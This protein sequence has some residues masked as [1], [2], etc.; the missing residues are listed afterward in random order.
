MTGRG[1]QVTIAAT[2]TVA[3]VGL[4][5]G[6]RGTGREVRSMASTAPP[7][8]ARVVA[9]SYADL[10]KAP[11]GVNAA[12]SGEWFP[13]LRAATAP[14]LDAP[15][16]QTDE[17][18][19][20]AV[21]ARAERRAFDGAPPTIPHRV[22]QLGVP[23]CLACHDAGL[24]VATKVAP[25]MSHEP[26]ASCLQ[27]HV[28][29]ADPRAAVAAAGGTPAAPASDFVGRRADYRGERAWTGAPPQL[30]HS[31]QM[32]ERC[33]SCH[34]PLGALGV[35][36]THPWRQSC[37]QCHAPSATFE[38]RAPVALPASAGGAPGGAR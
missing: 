34:G 8:A 5:S 11:R 23:A 26:M 3:A 24:V 9:P 14:K 22:D 33:D 2:L 20:R 1:L 32:R 21:A 31:T 19:A 38:Q 18:R 28:V 17:D 29:A 6:V 4:V 10:R 12:A 16:P 7:P 36:T 13:V 25:R 27:C 30:P 15:P 37:L 35:R